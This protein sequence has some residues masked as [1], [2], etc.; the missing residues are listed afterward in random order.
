MEKKYDQEENK[1]FTNI[2]PSSEE[3]VDWNDYDDEDF[4]EEENPQDTPSTE[5]PKSSNDIEQLEPSYKDKYSRTGIYNKKPSFRGSNYN[6]K[7]YPTKKYFK[8]KPKNF[9]GGYDSHYQYH[10]TDTNYSKKR[11]NDTYRD[12]YKYFKDFEDKDNFSFSKNRNFIEKNQY[13]K[14]YPN[15]NYQYRAKTKNPYYD[16]KDYE[17]VKNSTMSYSTREFVE[18][19]DR[20][21]KNKSVEK[22]EDEEKEENIAKPLFYNSKKDENKIERK[23]IM[24]DD[25]LE[26]RNI[27]N[28][29]KQI[30]RETLIAFRSEIKK[31]LEEEY[32]SLNINAKNY[33]PKK[34]FMQ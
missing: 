26:T 14:K 29:I 3:M 25:F 5:P 11:F 22:E 23:H 27:D 15:S 12:K 21:S 10:H 28:N 24:T 4:E 31:N 8:N 2:V 32:G 20:N 19:E 30:I 17:R 6:S 13:S 1:D 9:R 16:N 34:K 33:V 7:N 18:E